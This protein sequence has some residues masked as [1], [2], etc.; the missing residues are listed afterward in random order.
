[1]LRAIVHIAKFIC[2]FF[3][4]NFAAKHYNHSLQWHTQSPIV[5]LLLYLPIYM[6]YE[7]LIAILLKPIKNKLDKLDKQ[8]NP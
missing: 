1:M 6:G 5:W 4:A 2:I 7:S 8:H 3:A